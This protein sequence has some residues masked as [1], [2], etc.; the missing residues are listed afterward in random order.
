MAEEVIPLIMHQWEM[1]CE[2]FFS[3]SKKVDVTDHVATV[4]SSLK[5]LRAQDWVATHHADL[6]VL[7]FSDFMIELHCE[8][9]PNSWNNNLYIK[10]CSFHLK[11]SNF[12][13]LWINKL[14]H[15]NIIL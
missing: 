1:A 14:H 15:L 4:L 5:D 7:S 12:F 6:V 3:A 13:I 10:I 8:F 11:L 2:D 9:L